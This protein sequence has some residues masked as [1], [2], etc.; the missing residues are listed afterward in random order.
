[1]TEDDTGSS[2]LRDRATTEFQQ[3][4]QQAQSGSSR[5]QDRA[6]TVFQRRR[7]QAQRTREAIED[8][9]AEFA[10]ALDLDDE[11]IRPVQL[12]DR[13]EQIGFVP[14][15]R[16]RGR[17]A[18]RFADP[19]PFVEPDEA[20]VD[21]DPRRGVRTRTDPAA[22]DRIADRAVSQF[23]ADDEFA[24]ADDFAVEVGPGGVEDARLT[25]AGERRRAS[26]QFAA[27][28]PVDAF[29]PTVDIEPADDGFAL[30]RA[31]QR[32]VAAREFEQDLDVF[33]RGDL[34]PDDDI[35]DTNGGFGLQRG[36]ARQ[37]AAR[38][39]DRQLPEIDV[40]PDDIVLEETETGGFEAVFERE[41]R[42]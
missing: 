19:R 24:E 9:T 8:G 30:T 16:G 41:V 11:F 2:R 6:T 36:P 20:L 17:L 33:G 31:A 5:L 15:E 23:A 10:D 32:R 14:D 40:G 39:I 34:D 4:R 13:G 37:V 29:D 28:T 21:A 22:L 35:R 42:R 27:A 12:D 1:M 18:E 25:S 3:R 26:R 38:D 7:Q